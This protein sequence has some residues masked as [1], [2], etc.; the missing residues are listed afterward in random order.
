[1]ASRISRRRQQSIEHRFSA[2]PYAAHIAQDVLK[3][4]ADGIDPPDIVAPTA[5]SDSW[6]SNP[7]SLARALAHKRCRRHS[8]LL[9]SRGDG[10]ICAS[11]VCVLACTAGSAFP[12]L[13][14]QPMRRS[15]P[16]GWMAK[17]AW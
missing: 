9:G 3:L 6:K 2:S 11:F 14:L 1:M 13:G 7:R 15:A 10:L 8:Q 17:S 16:S 4:G 5:V 12:P